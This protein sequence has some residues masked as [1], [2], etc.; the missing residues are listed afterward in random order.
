MGSRVKKPLRIKIISIGN[1][2]VGKS[3]IIKRYCEKRFVSKYLQTI[4][5]DYGVTKVN[6]RDR[7]VK[8]NIFDMSGHQ[9]FHEV[10]NEF[11]KDTQG[12]ILVFDVCDKQSFD[13]LDD[14]IQEMKQ[15][16]EY[17]MSNNNNNTNNN[18]INN[19]N[20]NNTSTSLDNIVFVVCGNK[21]DKGSNKRVIDEADAR[22]W[23]LLKGYQYFE[24]SASSGA[25]VNEMFEHL[26]SE[27]V[28][29]FENGGAKPQIQN[30]LS[31]NKE[32]IEAIQRLK[33][34]KDNYERLGLRAGCTKEEINNSFRRLA[35]LLHP[36]KNIYPGSGDAF[37]ILLSAKTDLLKN[38]Q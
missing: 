25:G 31:L 22:M 9:I 6:F 30:N 13:S 3:C 23:A 7:E 35:K 19:N 34:S 1:I 12:V 33:N 28:N 11:Y 20:G 36:D 21:I 2:E 29:V 18:N 5:I 10:R 15:D 14:W 24:T 32:Q 38:F 17:G 26:L 27:I 4:G 16:L 37:K 8:V